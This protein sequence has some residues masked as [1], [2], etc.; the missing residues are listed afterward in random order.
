M[1]QKVL[2]PFHV[3][4]FATLHL[5]AAAGIAMENHPTAFNEILNKCTTISCSRKFLRGFTSPQPDVPRNGL[6]AFNSLER[7]GISYRFALRYGR[8]FIKQMLDEGL[9]VYCARID[10]YYI[11][12]KSWYGIRH[13]AHDG[14]ICGY[15]ETDSTY[16]MAAY[17]TD[18]VFRLI[19]ITQ[20]CY[21]EAAQS[22]LERHEYGGITGYRA[23]DIDVELD[24]PLILDY[25]KDHLETTIDTVS[26]ES[27]GRVSGIAVY[28]LLAMY[29]D[30][31]KDGSIPSEKMDWRALRPV[32]EHKRCML[33]RLKAIEKRHDWNPTYSEQYAPL[34]DEANRVR[35]MYAIFQKTKKPNL[36]DW[37]RNGLLDLREKEQ[38]I[39][40]G[41][42]EKMEGEV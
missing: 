41:F 16:L 20:S 32:W 23:K 9:Y 26:L 21:M 17:D 27:D 19:R 8:E 35:V 39:L 34:V 13:M 10:D 5:H 11:P 4:M 18:W 31:L 29:V 24:E 42:V 2:L 40:T 15:D 14:I 33:E 25:L 30:K 3:P 12:E 1:A 7:Y 38:R 28:D 22:C 36:L 6:Y 37:I